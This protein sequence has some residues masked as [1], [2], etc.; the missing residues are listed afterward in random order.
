MCG[1][2]HSLCAAV[3]LLCVEDGDLAVVALVFRALRRVGA[4]VFRALRVLGCARHHDGSY[5]FRGSRSA[6]EIRTKS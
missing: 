4:L 6:S 3:A 1:L 5:P 2:F